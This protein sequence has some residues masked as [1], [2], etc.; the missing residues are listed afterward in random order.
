M[1]TTG[2][3]TLHGALSALAASEA[4]QHALFEQSGAVQLIVDGPSGTILRAND[5]AER[6]YG[7]PRATM[8]S[9]CITDLDGTT[10]GEWSDAVTTTMRDGV[11]LRRRHR[12]ASGEP[13]EVEAFAA[14]LRIDDR[15]VVHLIVQDISAA[16]RA[17]TAL[18]AAE[19]HL[20][21]LRQRAGA[22]GHDFNNVLTVLRG[23]TAFLQDA[24][25]PDSP[26][27]E[28]VAALER[29]ADRAETLVRDLVALLRRG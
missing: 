26:S 12:V 19:L 11:P 25:A 15:D 29:A 8:H 18:H 5:A 3:P 27:Q 23:A 20:A 14:C 7:W 22:T 21:S 24:I 4:R 1:T 6:F 28:D 13:R 2:E 16:A 17:E 10:L 9:M